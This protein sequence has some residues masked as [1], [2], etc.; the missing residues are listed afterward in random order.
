MIILSDRAHHTTTHN[1]RWGGDTSS[2][3]VFGKLI[4]YQV[5]GPEKLFRPSKLGGW[6]QMFYQGISTP[7]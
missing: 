2:A 7:V 4:L 5:S 3:Q 6:S 1:A